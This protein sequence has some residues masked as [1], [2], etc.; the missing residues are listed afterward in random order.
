MFF[1]ASITFLIKNFNVFQ[2]YTSARLNNGQ[3][4]FNSCL[5]KEKPVPYRGLLKVN[6]KNK[7]KISLALFP[8][9]IKSALQISHIK[10]NSI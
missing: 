9:V 6:N 5:T 8:D 1:S 4:Q 2:I 3:A 10:S 7:L